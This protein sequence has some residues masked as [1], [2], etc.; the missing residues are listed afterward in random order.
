[1]IN[2]FKKYIAL[3][4]VIIIIIISSIFYFLS[5]DDILSFDFV[6]AQR[7]D[8]VQEV[9]VTG[10]VKPAESVDLAFEKI[11]SVSSVGVS[12]GDI[13]SVGQFLVRLKNGE[14]SAELEKAKASVK[15]QQAK[16]QELVQ[17]YTTE[18]I[19]VQ[20]VKVSNAQ[21]LLVEA[22]RN[23]VIK[24]NDA[25]TKADD[26]IRNNIDQF[27]DN[28]RSSN[29]QISFQVNDSSLEV[30]V[31]TGRVNIESVL[32][33]WS[34]AGLE[35][36]SVKQKL[37]QVRDYLDDV[38]F[39]VNALTAN[40]N[41]SQTIIDGYRA[42]VSTARTNVNTALL[43][44]STAE[45]KVQTAKLSLMLEQE[46]LELKIAGTRA[47]QILAQ[48]AKVEEAQASVR[49]VQAEI[50]KT[51]LSAPINGII[52]KQEA[53]VG[54]IISAN[55]VIVSIISE[56]EFE[57][58]SNVPEADIAK[59]QNGDK[60]LVTLDAYGSN[61]IFEAVVVAIDP[62]ETIIEGVATYKITLQFIKKDKRVRPGMTAN[63]DIKTDERTNVVSIP[64]R[65][66]ITNNGKNIVKI[67]DDEDNIIE[68]EVIVGLRG[69]Q[70]LVEVVSGIKQGDRVIT[71]IEE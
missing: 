38:S 31:E 12:V 68:V 66:L 41:F 2:L 19:N 54:E 39:V 37:T 5:K 51:Y 9:N 6:I 7:T 21:A 65:A 33:T 43:N 16:L 27:I 10:R 49:S 26:A 58:E 25:F 14:K 28:P 70:G 40:V 67:L 47:E 13:V 20:E 64:F 60:A 55:E 15:L 61:V 17:G 36:E 50:D 29:P 34:D 44:I 35:V 11:G 24:L 56:S 63:I 59:I 22:Q 23:L 48:E 62:A 69:S 18:E 53:K 1:M 30:K 8:L 71:F 3:T 45:E 4:V 46:E 57:I 42:D 52:I 32:N